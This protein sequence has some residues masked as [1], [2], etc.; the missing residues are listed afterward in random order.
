MKIWLDDIRP[1]PEGYTWCKSVNEAKAK[2]VDSEKWRMSGLK[3]LHG[4]E[5]TVI[6]CDHDLGDFA[7]DGG[8][9]IELLNWLEISMREYPIHL[10]TMNPVG[11]ERMR[12]VIRKNGWKEI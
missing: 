12:S 4:F 3:N 11:R 6:D 8:D 5:I 1:A 7:K 10:H 9:G 2:I